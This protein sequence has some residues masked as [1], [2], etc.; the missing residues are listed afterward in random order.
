MAEP[1]TPGSSI[2]SPEPPVEQNQ[3]SSSQTTVRQ[4][5]G[6][7]EFH[8]STFQSARSVF[9]LDGKA[10]QKVTLKNSTTSEKSSNSTVINKIKTSSSR[11]QKNNISSSDTKPNSGPKI[12][13]FGQF[14]SSSK[15]PPEK[16]DRKNKMPINRNTITQNII[17]PEQNDQISELGEP[18]KQIVTGVS[19]EIVLK[20]WNTL[21]SSEAT[22]GPESFPPPP[23][24]LFSTF[25][26]GK[27][28]ARVAPVSLFED[29]AW[30]KKS[31]KP[32]IITPKPSSI[33]I[34]RRLSL[35]Q[36][37]S[38]NTVI[39]HRTKPR[40]ENEN[41]DVFQ[42]I[43][44]QPTL[45][46]ENP[47]NYNQTCN[48]AREGMKT[49][50]DSIDS[51]HLIDATTDRSSQFETLQSVEY[52]RME[53]DI[54][55]EQNDSLDD[56]SI[57]LGEGKAIEK[58]VPLV[59]KS[60]TVVLSDGGFLFI[61]DESFTDSPGNDT[62]NE[63]PTR[64]KDLNFSYISKVGVCNECHNAG[65]ANRA[66][67]NTE[68]YLDE[69]PESPSYSSKP[70]P[71]SPSNPPIVITSP[72]STAVNTPHS[73]LLDLISTNRQ[74]TQVNNDPKSKTEEL[75]DNQCMH[76]NLVDGKGE[77]S[78]ISGQH[79]VITTTPSIQSPDFVSAEQITLGGMDGFMDEALYGLKDGGTRVEEPD[80]DLKAS[81]PNMPISKDYDFTTSRISIES[82]PSALLS[83][84]A[85][86]GSFSF[87]ADSL[88]TELEQQNSETND[89]ISN[90]EKNSK[91]I[92]VQ[93]PIHA[94]IKECFYDDS[95][96]VY[97]FPDGH[98]WFEIDPIKTFS[99]VDE[100]ALEDIYYK[101]PT[102]I[103]F[104]REP[105]QQFSTHSVEDYDR[106]NDEVDPVAASAE[107][108]LE[109]RVEKMSTFAV[110]LEKGPGGLGLSII[111]MGVGADSGLEKLGIFVK[112]I[113]PGGASEKDG[114]IKVNDQII[115]VDGHN[116]VGVTQGYAATVLRNTSGLVRFIMGREKDSENSE[117]AQ[118]IMM[119]MQPDEE[120]DQSWL[121]EYWSEREQMEHH[122]GYL[123]QV[124]EV[125]EGETSA[126]QGTHID[127]EDIDEKVLAEQKQSSEQSMVD[128]L[129][130]QLIEAKDHNQ[131]I[132]DEMKLLRS[133]LEE[134]SKERDA[135]LE[136]DLEKKMEENAEKTALEDKLETSYKEIRKYQDTLQ[137]S[138]EH[139]E[140]A[141]SMIEE[142]QIRHIELLD[143][144]GTAKRV[145]S[146]YKQI[147]HVLSDQL[148]S[149]DKTY[150]TYLRRMRETVL[151]QYEE[152]V[153]AQRMIGLQSRLPFCKKTIRGLLSP[154]KMLRKTPFVPS[155]P[156]KAEEISEPEDDP[157]DDLDCLVPP[158][159]LLDNTA[160]KHKSE[161]VQRRI[162]TSRHKPS[163]DILRNKVPSNDMLATP[164]HS[165]L[166]LNEMSDI[167][168]S[169]ASSPLHNR[170]RTIDLEAES[171]HLSKHDLDYENISTKHSETRHEI[172][173]STDHLRGSQQHSYSYKTPSTSVS[174]SSASSH[175]HLN[176]H[177]GH[178]H[179]VKE[180]N[181]EKEKW[182]FNS[183]RRSHSSHSCH[184]F[185]SH[186]PP[187]STASHSHSH[188]HQTSPPSQSI[189]PTHKH[190]HTRRQYS[191]A[192]H[193]HEQACQADPS[194]QA[195]HS[196][197]SHP[198]HQHTQDGNQFPQPG[199]YSL[200]V[201]YGYNYTRIE[202]SH[203]GVIPLEFGSSPHTSR[204]RPDLL[205][206]SPTQERQSPRVERKQQQSLTPVV[207]WSAHQV[208][209]WLQ[210][211]GMQKYSQAFL[212]SAISGEIILDIDSALLK[213]LGVVSKTDRDRI[214]EKVKD[215]RKLSEKGR[216][217]D[218]K[219]R[220]RRMD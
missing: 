132:E 103:K 94:A 63:T 210:H 195:G 174:A 206:R 208:A 126:S 214:K 60:E 37:N 24:F 194:Q 107:Y 148:I 10:S 7:T 31:E 90:N 215:L 147:S 146:S 30:Q 138:Q 17:S 183:Y 179:R 202:P 139:L 46:Q 133:K 207:M 213:Q 15:P 154:P 34:V 152:L 115:E 21:E 161:L 162:P 124:E 58:I 158:H 76:T 216:K 86:T 180:C 23:P 129:S 85:E 33:E 91:K 122:P 61:D 131:Q 125:E 171:Q 178:K 36:R 177:E 79:K 205:S 199:L 123:S 95:A 113:T 172:T 8:H 165:S 98:Y 217:D 28:V 47:S 182:Q 62:K 191:E 110:E 11:Y 143:K 70:L 149:R 209:G 82:V 13:Q 218:R 26:A 56:I 155:M 119:S 43:S 72:G 48:D 220:R 145:I 83:N 160:A 204:S 169:R 108:E 19:T 186:S 196:A 101:H 16:P 44:S 50:K 3:S 27:P 88:D 197:T 136:R 55:V 25:C 166:K 187:P 137:Q 38:D 100:T 52:E 96:K 159:E 190:S 121:E 4:E 80:I 164:G 64:P 170:T 142:S 5:T 193:H 135:K 12:N 157:E 176:S 53:E 104:S 212:D 59:K 140:S 29:P 167:E 22:T 92:K 75:E 144:Y 73:T 14:A 49:K 41:W 128:I 114:R 2:P 127:D 150:Y 74:D 39:Q 168:S 198:D 118:L 69:S 200:D 219:Q 211:I 120:E 84:N 1:W 192:P 97:Y 201:E 189:P 111:G 78:P 68:I 112:T 117:V 153:K 40:N 130:L 18:N 99:P 151:M 89:E 67:P 185:D 9:Q 109:K 181:K 65:H 156:D 93:K 141:Q 54:L 51:L 45:E 203:I 57:S 71:M 6:K 106:R 66:K 173:R 81:N 32:P 188:H 116:L 102:R 105:I 163:L 77:V 134:F 175:Q 20:N 184:K 42:E 87:S 35:N